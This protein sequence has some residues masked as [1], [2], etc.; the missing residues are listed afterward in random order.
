MTFCDCKRY[1]D[2]S[3]RICDLVYCRD[4]AADIHAL[5]CSPRDIRDVMNRQI[6]RLFLN[7]ELGNIKPIHSI[8]VNVIS[9]Y[10]FISLDKINT[11]IQITKKLACYLCSNSTNV[12][13][14]NMHLGFKLTKDCKIQI[15]DVGYNTKCT[16]DMYIK[17][18][19]RCVDCAKN[20]KRLCMKCYLPDDKCKEYTNER[21]L[22][23][24]PLYLYMREMMIQ[25]VFYYVIKY[26]L[27]CRTFDT[28]II[29]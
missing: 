13:L 5:I 24:Y 17:N 10:C 8:D 16:N 9:Q 3:C 21:L 18:I 11:H 19:P 12:S 28:G 22:N 14:D 6:Q 2:T 20:N 1:C 4:C 25:D 26:L 15:Y 27:Y 23:S 29:D 7:I